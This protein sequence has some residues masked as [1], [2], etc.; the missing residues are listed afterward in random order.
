MSNVLKEVERL[1]AEFEREYDDGWGF[2]SY[3]VDAGDVHRVKG[4]G[5]VEIVESRTGGEGD[6][7]VDTYLVFKVTD[8]AGTVRYYRKGGTYASFSGT[9]WYGDFKEVRPQEKTVLVYE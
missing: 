4:L 7:E 8:V 3:E 2:W 1:L 9:E 6:Y 5:D